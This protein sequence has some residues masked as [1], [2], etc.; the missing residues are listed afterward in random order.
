MKLGGYKRPHVRRHKASAGEYMSR[1]TG[2]NNVTRHDPTPLSY[3]N[4]IE[5]RLEQK[6]EQAALDTS[7]VAETTVGIKAEEKCE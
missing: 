6:D 7:T 3:D 5:F 4:F 1:P 2:R